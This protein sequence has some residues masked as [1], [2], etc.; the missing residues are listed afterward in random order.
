MKVVLKLRAPISVKVT[1]VAGLMS[2]CVRLDSLPPAKATPFRVNFEDG[3]FLYM[4]NEITMPSNCGQPPVQAY[5][6]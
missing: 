6:E 1:K 5:Q 3:L 4:Q 2:S